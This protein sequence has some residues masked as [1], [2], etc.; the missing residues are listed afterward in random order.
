MKIATVAWSGGLD[1]TV[2]LH[3]V[4][5]RGNY[6]HVHAHHVKL[7]T[8]EGYDRAEAEINSCSQAWYWFQNKQMDFRLTRSEYEC[9]YDRAGEVADLK[10]L[11]MPMVQ[12]LK[13]EFNIQ[14]NAGRTVSQASLVWGDHADEFKRHEFVIRWDFISKVFEDFW[15]TIF[16]EWD[17]LVPHVNMEIP[18]RYNTKK[19]NWE[20]CPES[21]RK[22]TTS[23]RKGS[24][25]GNCKT[26]LELYA[27]RGEDD[28]E[29]IEN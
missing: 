10:L 2:A 23:C 13:Q 12:A 28:T 15:N 11:I 17:G 20:Y 8:Q 6:D 22:L 19:D 4:L 9:L 25:C 14:Y 27:A 24:N 3:K 7:L 21:L 29:Y 1:S 18:N 26:C 5:T 16:C